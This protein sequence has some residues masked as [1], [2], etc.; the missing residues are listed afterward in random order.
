MD[1]RNVPSLAALRAF[2]AAV[3]TGSLTA[4]AR[5]LNVT[6]A[7]I[8][9]HVR[10][11]EDHLAASLLVRS[12]RKMEPTVAGQTLAI[13]LSDGFG[14]VIAGVR[15]VTDTGED[16]ALTMTMTPSFA[17][18]WLMPRLGHLWSSHP[19]ITVSITPSIALCDLRREG[20]DLGIRYGTG[21][22]PGVQSQF[23]MP[24]DYIVVAAP[25]L[26]GG[27]QARSIAD[28]QDL[29]WI[30]A[31]N[32]RESRKW[33]EDNGLDLRC[34]QINEVPTT[35]LAMAAVRAGVGVSIL[36][37]ALLGPDL[38]GGRVVP[39]LTVPPDASG[40]HIVTHA[41]V[42]SEKLRR[43]IKWIKD[44]VKTDVNAA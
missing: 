22:W 23:L 8:A 14:T 40:Y 39:I 44:Q 9:Q 12:G 16:R 29:P 35:P 26:L 33:A 11:L 42:P 24:A 5:E 15:A 34:C 28:L 7:A 10:T 31:S 4:A 20:F 3:R 37:R 6:H 17:E 2:E 27:R 30:F 43:L 1:W 21:P 25:S 38:A 19:D 32:I 36:S 18:N 13:A 41:Q